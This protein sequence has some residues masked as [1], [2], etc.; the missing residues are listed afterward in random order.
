MESMIAYAQQLSDNLA[1]YESKVGQ[2]NN[3]ANI[4]LDDLENGQDQHI[5]DVQEMIG[6]IDQILSKQNQITTEARNTY[7]ELEKLPA[8]VDA[9]NEGLTKTNE[10]LTDLE[11]KELKNLG[12]S[13]D[14]NASKITEAIQEGSNAANALASVAANI[15][16]PTFTSTISKPKKG[17]NINENSIFKQFLV[18]AGYKTSSVTWKKAIQ[19]FQELIGTK[20]DGIAGP[21]T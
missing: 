19:I 17:N 8:P 21:N 2:E 10:L 6:S 5:A 12:F 18:D 16:K 11:K 3:I 4:N 14:P 13:A 15:T 7:L 1:D 9:L 20:A